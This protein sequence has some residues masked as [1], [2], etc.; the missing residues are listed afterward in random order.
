MNGDLASMTRANASAMRS[1]RASSPTSARSAGSHCETSGAS[2]AAQKS[3][4]PQKRRNASTSAGSNQRPRR[5]LAISRA[6]LTPPA[7]WNTSTV[8]ARHRIRAARGISSPRRP[9]GMPRPSQCSSRLRIAAAV[10]S[11]RNSI[12]AISAPRSH[13]ASMNL[14]VT[15]PSSRIPRSTSKRRRSPAPGATVRSDH[16]NAARL[17][18]QSTSFEVALAARSSAANSAAMRLALAEQPASLS[19]RA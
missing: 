15:S 5:R 12:R 4:S 3:R 6:A 19:S 14:R 2:S 18:V 13:R 16:R 7:A 1:R 9:S 11:D 10:S 17:S 8:C